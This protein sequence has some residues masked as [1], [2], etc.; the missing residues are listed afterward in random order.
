MDRAY[1]P[2]VEEGETGGSL[3]LSRQPSLAKSVGS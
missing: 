3:G 1:N 2:S